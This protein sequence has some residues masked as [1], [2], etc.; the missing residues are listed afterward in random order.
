MKMAELVPI[1][2]GSKMKMAE[3]VPIEK[4]GKNENGK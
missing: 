2:K 3:L 1:E 4:G